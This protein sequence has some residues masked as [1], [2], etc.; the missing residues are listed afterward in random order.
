MHDRVATTLNIVEEL[1]SFVVVVVIVNAV[2]IIV[3]QLTVLN[4]FVK[5]IKFQHQASD[6]AA[7]M[8]RTKLT[9]ILRNTKKASN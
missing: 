9:E 7:K 4:L 6:S 3:I 5:C 1:K 2:I 8:L